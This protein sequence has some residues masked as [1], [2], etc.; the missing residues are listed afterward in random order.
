MKKTWK[1]AKLISFTNR[2]SGCYAEFKKAVE[3]GCNDDR[4]VFV[5]LYEQI[6]RAVA[7]LPDEPG[8]YIRVA[9]WRQ[10]NRDQDTLDNIMAN[11]CD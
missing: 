6:V 2:N 4:E 10:I 8:S 3:N 9:M 11:F 7:S 5:K 1:E